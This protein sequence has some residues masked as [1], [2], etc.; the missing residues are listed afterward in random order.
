MAKR[1]EVLVARKKL[2]FGVEGRREHFVVVQSD[3][4]SEL[5]T[6][7]VAPLDESAPMYEDDPIV[8]HLQGKDARGGRPQV[9][10]VHLLAAAPADR[11]EAAAVGRISAPSMARIDAML[12]TVLH[13]DASPS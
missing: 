7:L 4:L 13:L 9:V 12:R 1:G 5:D 8:V 3:L 10:L 6:L 2:G 11:F